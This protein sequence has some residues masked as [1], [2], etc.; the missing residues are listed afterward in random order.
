MSLPFF[1]VRHSTRSIDE[2]VA[3]LNPHDIKLVVDV[4]TVP[5]SRINPQCNSKD[6]ARARPDFRLDYQHIPSL[7]G[8]RGRARDLSQGTNAFWKNQSFQNYAS[9]R[10]AQ[11]CARKPSG[12]DVT[13]GSLPTI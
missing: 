3:L 7:G 1:A 5:R 11:S 2:F 6:F 12:G 10:H 9:Q 8:L 13:E 4:R